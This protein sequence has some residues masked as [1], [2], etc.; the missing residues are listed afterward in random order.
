[1]AASVG[2]RGS[3]QPRTWPASTSV[4]SFR[5]LITVCVMFS[6]EYS[7]TTGLYSRSTCAAVHGRR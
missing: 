7:H 1:M 2:S 5:L 6:R 4:F 3:S